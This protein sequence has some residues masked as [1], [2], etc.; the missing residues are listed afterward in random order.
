M[1]NF[2]GII[3]RIILNEKREEAAAGMSNDFFTSNSG[4]CAPNILLCAGRGF[5]PIEQRDQIRLFLND[6]GGKIS[7]YKSS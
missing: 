4:D 7:C 1:S 3:I 6:C 2:G 5:H